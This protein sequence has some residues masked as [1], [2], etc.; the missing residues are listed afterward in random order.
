MYFIGLGCHVRLRAMVAFIGHVEFDA[1]KGCNAPMRVLVISDSKVVGLCFISTTS[2][3][4]ENSTRNI[5][6]CRARCM[7]LRIASFA[8]YSM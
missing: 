5:F 7:T 2:D 4:Q 3:L 1:Q 8:L 6:Y